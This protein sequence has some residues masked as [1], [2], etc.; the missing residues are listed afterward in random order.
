MAELSV[1][2]RNMLQEIDRQ[3]DEPQEIIR[4]VL[5]LQA[6]ATEDLI[7]A[8]HAQMLSVWRDTYEQFLEIYTS[9][10]LPS[11]K[12]KAMNE[13][14]KALFIERNPA[15][16]LF[17]HWWRLLEDMPEDAVMRAEPEGASPGEEASASADEPETLSESAAIAEQER[18]PISRLLFRMGALV[19]LILVVGG[20]FSLAAEDNFSSLLAAFAPSPTATPGPTAT[21]LPTELP[22]IA[23]KDSDEPEANPAALAINATGAD[24]SD[25]SGAFEATVEP[26]ATEPPPPTK[27]PEPTATDLPTLTPTPE[28]TPTPIFTATPALPPEGL[29]GEQNLLLLYGSSLT[30]PF[31]NEQQFRPSDGSWRIG[32]SSET[33]GDTIRVFPPADLLESRYGNSAPGRI[34][35]VEADLTLRSFN[36]AVVSGDDVYFGIILQSL[37]GNK[38]AGIQ[39][40]A[41]GPNVINLARVQ[42][43]AANFVSQRSVNAVIARLRLEYDRENGVVFA[44]YNDSQIG[45]ALPLDATDGMVLP[46]IFAKD[47]GVIIGVSS[48]RITLT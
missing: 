13:G 39:V 1:K 38:S 48:W 36:P 2:R 47:G 14:F 29:K 8:A 22:A 32:I 9:D 33:E 7:G 28:D 21:A 34:S 17:R 3:P 37:S 30:T 46:V 20:L 10:A 24:V 12:T 25:K 45:S 23:D 19:G 35:R 42:D 41:V 31:W 44:Y 40:Q 6:D 27:T 43:G 16:P 5:H 18:S 11:Q 15:Y 4:D 26:V